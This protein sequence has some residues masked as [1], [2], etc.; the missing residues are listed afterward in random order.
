VRQ[1]SHPHH[2]QVEAALAD[3]SRD[4]RAGAAELLGRAAGVF[5]ALVA[6]GVSVIDLTEAHQA[7]LETAVALARAQPDMAP[8]ARLASVAL[9]AARRAA[10]AKDALR[11]AEQAARDFVAH[12]AHAA[13]QTVAH[14]A[15]LVADQSTVLTH[16]RSS[17][18]LA[19]LWRAQRAGRR[20]RVVVTES[21]PQMEGRALAEA[22]AGE[23]L[24]VTFIAD[25]AA[26][27]VLPQVDLVMV[28]AD[29]VTAGELVNKVGTRLIALG[30]RE[31]GVK[32]VALC[33]TSKFVA[34]WPAV[35]EAGHSP[36]ELWPGA[37]PAV[38]VVNRYFE[39]TPLDYF[40]G[41]ITEDG[42]LAPREAASRAAGI[43]I[44]P[45]VLAALGLA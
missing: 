24:G 21:R 31:R 28:G 8:L 3:L 16:S 11:L 27:L 13:E 5:A 30:A 39:P 19:T 10:T 34:A 17:T 26:A 35:G 23:S 12:A 9:D 7:V 44:S 15:A 42:W 36:D 41:I 45:S 4:N 37:P 43:T 25:A 40:S 33:D 32:V 6:E 38:E 18:V 20:F 29:R 22:L 1:D 2:P 14:A